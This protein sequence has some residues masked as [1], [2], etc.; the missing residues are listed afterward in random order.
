MLEMLI[1]IPRDCK[2]EKSDHANFPG[3]NE[4]RMTK[5]AIQSQCTAAFTLSKAMNIKGNKNM[6]VSEIVVPQS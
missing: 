5:T 3:I 4:I 6:L 2:V 1:D